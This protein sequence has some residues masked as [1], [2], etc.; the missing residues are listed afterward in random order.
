MD[1]V[2]IVHYQ[3]DARSQ[4]VAL[5]LSAQLHRYEVRSE[6]HD[7]AHSSAHELIYCDAIVLAG[8]LH[9]SRMHG[10]ALINASFSFRPTALLLTGAGDTDRVLRLL[11]AHMREKVPVFLV[12]PREAIAPGI[13]ALVTWLR[14]VIGAGGY[15]S[16]SRT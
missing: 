1:T 8:P 14:E 3:R 16:V 11:P 9:F 4:A 13:D 10:L 2:A 7:V 6:L 15:R 12:G 5:E